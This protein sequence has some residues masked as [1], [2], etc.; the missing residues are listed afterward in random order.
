M[1]HA[2][3]EVLTESIVPTSRRHCEGAVLPLDGSQRGLA[4]QGVGWTGELQRSDVVRCSLCVVQ[5]CKFRTTT[6][7]IMCVYDI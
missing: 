6:T 7:A 4:A 3:I 1:V 5:T 2:V